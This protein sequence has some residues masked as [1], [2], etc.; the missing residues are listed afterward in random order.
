MKETTVGP[1]AAP[2]F[3]GRERR[4]GENGETANGRCQRP[5]AVGRGTRRAEDMANR[6]N[7]FAPVSSRAVDVPP[8]LKILNP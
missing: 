2:D 7:H 6:L 3:C 5:D 1:L 8:R 4:E